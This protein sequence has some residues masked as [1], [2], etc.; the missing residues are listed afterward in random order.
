M[1]LTDSTIRNSKPHAK[2]Y[3]VSDGGGLHLLVQT[4]GSKLWRLAYRFAGK[5]KTLALGSYPTVS[6][7]KAREGRDA[8][9]RLL[10]DGIDPSVQKRRQ[11]LAERVSANATFKAVAIEFVSNRRHVLTPRYADELLRRLEA[12]IFSAL[13][14]RPIADI[15]APEL[16]AV[17]RKVEKRG[18]LEQVR[19]LRQTIG[20]VFRYAMVTGRAKNDPSIALKGALKPKGRVRNHTPMPRDELPTFLRSLDSYDGDPR[21]AIA[22]RLIVLTMV[23][24]GELRTARWPEFEHL[25]APEPLWRVPADRMKMKTEHLVPLSRQAVATLNELREL[26][27]TGDGYLFPSP[28][29]EGFMSN[30]TMLYA[31]YRMGYHG[32]ATVHG[33]RGVASTILNEMGFP[34]D[35]IERQ[36][37]HD[38]RDDV[39]GAY[40]SAQYLSGRRQMLQHWGDFLEEVKSCGK[41]TLLARE[42][43]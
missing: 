12:D 41:V 28:S 14:H 8:A 37:A 10:S 43:A 21:T 31:L 5:Q 1:P 25:D 11:R 39:R 15:D 32:R 34:S 38:E 29:R 16:L 35:W 7:Q 26:P 3:K 36:L 17:L 20:Q 24:T 22:L 6:L 27:G 23:R 40:N 33:F 18:A 13:G 19:K 2:P 30:N 4:N 42:A 9:K